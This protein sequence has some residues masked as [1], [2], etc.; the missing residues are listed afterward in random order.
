[1]A[2]D[3]EARELHWFDPPVRAIIPLD[4]RFHVARRL[5]RTIRKV[6]YQMRLNTAFGE[7]LRACAAPARGREKTW[8][9]RDIVALYT[10]LHERGHAH[11]IEA[12]EGDE[13]VGGLYGVSLGAAFFGESMFSRKADASKIALIHLVALL[14]ACGFAL[15]DTQFMTDHLAQFGTLELSRAAYQ[16]LLAAAVA[17]PARLSEEAWQSW[18]SAPAPRNLSPTDRTPDVP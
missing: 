1:M 11:S 10:A 18:A 14:R 15:L 2:E 8:I 4:A 5:Q 13:L 17:R 3:A 16:R 6:P 9:N 7:V 12:W